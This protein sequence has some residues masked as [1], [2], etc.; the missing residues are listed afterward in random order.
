MSRSDPRLLHMAVNRQCYSPKALLHCR[1]CRTHHHHLCSSFAHVTLL[2]GISPLLPG[3]HGVMVL[4]NLLHVLKALNLTTLFWLQWKEMQKPIV[5]TVSSVTVSQKQRI[6]SSPAS[7][8]KSCCKINEDLEIQPWEIR[9]FSKD[10]ITS[11]SN[12]TW[13]RSQKRESPGKKAGCN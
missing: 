3:S 6:I 12:V 9:F 5:S 10:F 8:S 4:S 11:N 7:H 1:T 2:P 13:K